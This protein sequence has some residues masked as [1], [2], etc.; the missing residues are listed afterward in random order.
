MAEL[1]GTIHIKDG[2]VRELKNLSVVLP[3]DEE[4]KAS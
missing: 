4:R 2:K 3:T 1:K